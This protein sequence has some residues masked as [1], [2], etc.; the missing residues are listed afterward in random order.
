MTTK[1]RPGYQQDAPMDVY[2]Y[3]LG[4]RHAREAREIGDGD[5]SEGVRQAIEETAARRRQ[6]RLIS[7]IQ[8]THLGEHGK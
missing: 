7:Q 2:S 1:L 5:G 6:E 8:R 3:R 4:A